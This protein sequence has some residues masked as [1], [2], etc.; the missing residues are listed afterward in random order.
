[1][2]QIV[3]GVDFKQLDNWLQA[4]TE[5]GKIKI[6]VL[7][8]AIDDI[9][10]SP[11]EGLDKADLRMVHKNLTKTKMLEITSSDVL[12]AF[13]EQIEKQY[14]QKNNQELD[15]FMIMKVRLDRY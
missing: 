5:E 4:I 2:W 8:N 6:S 3:T 11:V 10:V 9:D 12:R 14:G 15:Q 7:K 1:M 13:L